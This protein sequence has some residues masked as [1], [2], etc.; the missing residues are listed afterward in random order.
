MREEKSMEHRHMSRYVYTMTPG[1]VRR[2]ILPWLGELARK[3][4][5]RPEG[6]RRILPGMDNRQLG[7]WREPARP[8]SAA[9]MT[10]GAYPA[11][12]NIEGGR[13]PDKRQ[14]ML[15]LA[16]RTHRRALCPVMGET[17]DGRKR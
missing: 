5:G 4:W 9:G 16:E 7:A 3:A 6:R 11:H 17:G 14:P 13:K 2:G 10:G 8:N 12:E 15:A 1:R